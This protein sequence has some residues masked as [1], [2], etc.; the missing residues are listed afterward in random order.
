L[1]MNVGRRWFLVVVIV[2]LSLNLLGCSLLEQE[3]PSATTYRPLLAA[4]TPQTLAECCD[5]ERLLTD[6]YERVNPSVVSIQVI[7]DAAGSASAPDARS[8]SYNYQRGQGSGFVVDSSK[9]L[10]VTNNHVVEDAEMIQVVLWDAS[11][12]PAEVLGQDPDSDLAVLK[13]DVNGHILRSVNLGDSDTL[14]VGQRAIAIGNPFGWQGTLTT[15][16]ISGL[17]RTLRLGHASELVSSRFSIPEMIQTDAAINFGNSGGPLLDSA[18]RVIGV[19]TAMNSVTGA[20]AGVGFA[21][22]IN[23][24]KRVLPEL[25]EKGYYAYPWLGISGTDLRPIQVEAMNLSVNR[26]AII[27]A[28]TKDGPAIEAGLRGATGTIE[29]FGEDVGIGGDVIVGIDGQAVRQFD[30]LLVHLIKEKNPGDQVVLTIVR[31]GKRIETT[32]TLGER[33]TH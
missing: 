18:G 20:S 10:V 19:N 26:G 9:G 1:L 13:V 8:D 27:L 2:A 5:E 25:I 29:Y 23:T 22:P 4:S 31:D 33:P 14:A 7:R 28:T 3:M 15:G 24:V 17:G 16:I 30:D 32:L 21:I 6:L 11:V 12:L